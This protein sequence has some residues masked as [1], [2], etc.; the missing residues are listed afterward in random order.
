ME[1]KAARIEYPVS[2]GIDV[3][4]RQNGRLMLV[5]WG[6][7][8][9]EDDY[10][11]AILYLD[12]GD[13]STSL[14][15]YHPATDERER[16]RH[17][18]AKADECNSFMIPALTGQRLVDVVILDENVQVENLRVENVQNFLATCRAVV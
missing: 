2:S 17:F 10:L 11:G 18:I 7:P 15:F 3:V 14:Y 1:Q 8:V 4:C 6:Q 13:I 9:A 12:V 16:R 5:M